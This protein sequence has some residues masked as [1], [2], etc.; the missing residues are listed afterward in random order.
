[1]AVATARA[2]LGPENLYVDGLWN[3]SQ[4]L[5]LPKCPNCTGGEVFEGSFAVFGHPLYFRPNGLMFWTL[6]LGGV[7]VGVSQAGVHACTTCGMVW[8]ALDAKKLR[9]L[10]THAG[11]DETRARLAPP[12]EPTE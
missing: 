5:P 4:L 8:S 3:R 1:M 11:D 12:P 2:A 10:L 9:E 6:S 7:R